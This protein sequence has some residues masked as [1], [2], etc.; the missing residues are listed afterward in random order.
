MGPTLG[1]GDPEQ[2]GYAMAALLAWQIPGGGSGGLLPE[3]VASKIWGTRRL[4]SFPYDI[5]HL[6]K[7][8]G[9]IVRGL[10]LWCH[11]MRMTPTSTSHYHQILG[12]L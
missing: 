7:A 4:S 12:W 9:D 10:G 11:P 6:H 2:H 3:P 8:L 1:V 5:Y